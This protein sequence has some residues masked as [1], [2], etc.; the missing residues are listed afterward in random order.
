MSKAEYDRLTG[1]GL[2]VE[3]VG[4]LIGGHGEVVT[5]AAPVEPPRLLGQPSFPQP[6]I[7]FGM[8]EAD[9]HAIHAASTSALK[10]IAASP[11]D[12]W[13][14]SDLNPDKE[15][16][17]QKDYFDYGNAIHCLI[18][19]GEDVYA[20]RYVIGLEQPKDALVTTEQIK[21]RIAELGHKPVTKGLDDPARSAKKDDW[22]AQLLSLDPDARVW[23]LMKAAFDEE[24][25]GAEVVTFKMDRRVRI[26]TKMITAQRDIAE[27]FEGGY[28]EVSIFW[29][30]P[31]TGCPMKARLDYLK[32]DR[33][34]DLKSF[35]NKAS[36][37]I[38]RAVEREI[39]NNRYNVQHVVYDE[40]VEATKRMIR[41]QIEAGEPLDAVIF[42][43]GDP[44]GERGIVEWCQR[45]AKRPDPDFVF[46]FQKS[47]KAPV[48]RGKIMPRESMGVFGTTKRRVEH[49]KALFVSYCEVYG[50][51]PWLDIQ[52]VSHIDD[53]DLPLWSTEI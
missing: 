47:T 9:Y 14:E 26:A 28:P 46:V 2:D 19:E 45:L 22:V 31:L 16:R 50:T 33:I 7:Y 43:Q 40:A 4:D 48:V 41:Q 29:H 18:L 52:P 51:E 39:A 27:N 8:P 49:L 6:G 10:A 24:H 23:D 12:Y 17:G 13:H 21:A 25:A 53:G 36:M 35:S 11:A 30:C 34:V 38:D 1:Q 32:L 20:Q 15:E 3:T 5:P 37:P 42:N 44:K